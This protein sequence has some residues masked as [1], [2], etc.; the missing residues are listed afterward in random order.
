MQGCER[1]FHVVSKACIQHAGFGL[2]VRLAGWL[3][4]YARIYRFGLQA[5]ALAWGSVLYFQHGWG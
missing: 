2:Q 3:H 1:W 5:L 4:R